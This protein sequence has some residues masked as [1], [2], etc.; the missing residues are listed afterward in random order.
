MTGRRCVQPT[1]SSSWKVQSRAR[2]K[3]QPNIE[4]ESFCKSNLLKP[5]LGRYTTMTSR[6]KIFRAY[7]LKNKCVTST[8]FITLRALSKI[9]SSDQ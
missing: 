1:A 7:Y 8:G 9:I 3:V 4:P 6:G 2:R 5:G